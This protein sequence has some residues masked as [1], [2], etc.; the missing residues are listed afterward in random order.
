[1][2]TTQFLRDGKRAAGVTA[3][4]RVVVWNTE[5]GTTLWSAA[6]HDSTAYRLAVSPDG[7]RVV[8]GAGELI[9]WDATSGARL[10][11]TA[12]HTT[13]LYDLAFSADGLRLAWCAASGRLGVL[14]AVPLRDRLAHA[15]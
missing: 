1:M 8:S 12:V 5:A 6:G 14:D 15:P 13:G 3:T 7:R 10:I 9:V 2:S 11:T 4:G